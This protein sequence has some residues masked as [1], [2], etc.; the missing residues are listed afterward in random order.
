MKTGMS[1]FIRQKGRQRGN[2][3]M[4]I[5]GGQGNRHERRKAERERKKQ[6]KKAQAQQADDNDIKI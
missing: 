5:I 2:S 3:M 6:I 1:L 4:P